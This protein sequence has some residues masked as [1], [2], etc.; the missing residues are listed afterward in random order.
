MQNLALP[1]S[2]GELKL[3]E[4]SLI[5]W[6]K[7]LNLF[8]KLY[9]SS[10]DVESLVQVQK[11][12]SNGILL[13]DLVASLFNVKLHGIFKDPKTEA[14]A[15]ANIR[16]PLEVL[17]RQSRMS[18]KFTWAE[19]EIYEGRLSVVIGLFEDLHRCY[20]GLPSR[21]RGLNYF[22]DGPYLGDTLY[23]KNHQN[24]RAK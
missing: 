7:R 11:D 15:L 23:D 3:L 19:K 17:R 21:K 16:K 20:D 10:F 12:I 14:T 24:E 6:L 9:G 13:A 4:I 1:Y 5:N 18:Q 8:S 2:Q 22:S